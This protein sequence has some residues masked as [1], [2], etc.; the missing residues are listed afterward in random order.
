[1]LYKS[2]LA[3]LVF[4]SENLL[5]MEASSNISYSCIFNPYGFTLPYSQKVLSFLNLPHLSQHLISNSSL[6]TPCSNASV[7]HSFIQRSICFST[8]KSNHCL[9]YRFLFC[10]LA[11]FHTKDPKATYDEPRC[12]AHFV[13][14]SSLLHK[15]RCRVD[16]DLG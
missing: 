13:C 4:S 5:S 14:F 1:M 9:L 16:S 10:S 2:K 8:L 11:S 15:Y 3:H 12:R 6:P 7:S